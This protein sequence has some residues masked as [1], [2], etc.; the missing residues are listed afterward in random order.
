MCKFSVLGFLRFVWSEK[1]NLQLIVDGF[2]FHLDKKCGSQQFWQCIYC[3]K[4][5]CRARVITS[6]EKMEKR[7]SL[8]NHQPHSKI[9]KNESLW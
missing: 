8:H 3:E 4:T 1:S 2:L 9:I 5:K 7:R 6:G